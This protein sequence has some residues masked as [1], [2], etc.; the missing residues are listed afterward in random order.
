M[1]AF[2]VVV[3]CITLYM[4]FCNFIQYYIKYYLESIK[5]AYNFEYDCP[6]L[7]AQFTTQDAMQAYAQI[8]S[9]FAL[10]G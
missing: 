7:E 4:V 6:Y 1:V 9:Q 3:T 5:F 10:H 2:T 8:D